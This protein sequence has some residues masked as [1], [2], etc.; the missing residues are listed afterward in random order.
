MCTKDA[1]MGLV[2]ISKSKNRAMTMTEVA[3]VLGVMGLMLGALWAVASSV[4]DNYHFFK[5]KQNLI[6]T[7]QNVQTFYGLSGQIRDPATSLA[8]ADGT[9]I[10]AALDDETRRLIPIEMRSTPTVAGNPINH[11]FN[12]L[13]VGSFHVYS[14]SGGRT[15]RV[16]LSGLSQAQCAMLLMQ[17]PVLMK[18]IGVVRMAT[19]ADSSTVNPNNLAAPFGNPAL[20]MTMT[21][22]NQWCPIVATDTN[23]VSYDFR[24]RL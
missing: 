23:V 15:F 6:N 5:L 13:P 20:P 22:A 10:T 21:L 12:I 8:Y 17:F 9:D 3:I 1:S 19:Q 16:E 14:Q 24:V 11:N 4:W 2:V 7:V 18:E